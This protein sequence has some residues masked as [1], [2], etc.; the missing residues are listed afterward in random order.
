MI[1]GY[2]DRTVYPNIYTGPTNGG[3]MPLDSS[4]WPT[5][6]DG[7]AD[8]YQQNP[9][10]ASRNGLDGRATR[11]SL[12]DY[13]VYYLSGVQDPYI[14]NAWTQHTWGDAIGDYMKT[15]QSASSNDDGSTTFYN[16]DPAGIPVNL[17]RYGKL[18]Y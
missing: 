15:S 12:D 5:W 3:V 1:A 17:Q 16:L 10:I 9:L 2:Y 8:T 14:T 6:T 7:N 11:G 18:R 13:W 4:S